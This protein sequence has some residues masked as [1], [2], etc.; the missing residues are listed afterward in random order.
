MRS[1]RQAGHSASALTR[2]SAEVNAA[3]I[4]NTDHP[5]SEDRRQLQ[6][7]DDRNAAKQAFGAC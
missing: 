5:K 7:A 4:A 2:T 1:R 6:S 3:P